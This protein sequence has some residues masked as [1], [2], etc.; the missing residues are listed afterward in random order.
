[1]EC[2]HELCSREPTC[3][4]VMVATQCHLRIPQNDDTDDLMEDSDR[5]KCVKLLH[6]GVTYV[7]SIC[8]NG[9]DGVVHCAPVCLVT[10]D[11]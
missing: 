6:R 7:A 1:M 3:R 9:K 8:P 2:V 5:E 11:M 4:E 10:R